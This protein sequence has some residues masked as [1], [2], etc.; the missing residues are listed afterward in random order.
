MKRLDWLRK[1]AGRGATLAAVVALAG[2]DSGVPSVSSSST[3]ATVH[4]VV[5]YKGQPV[6]GGEI[7]FDPA[8][9]QRKDASLL[10]PARGG[11]EGPGRLRRHDQL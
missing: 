9:I 1:V 6:P 7:K 3:E 10:L 8:N 2:C 11:Q 5:K 4:G